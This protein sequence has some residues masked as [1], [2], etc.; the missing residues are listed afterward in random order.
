M[1]RKVMITLLVSM[2][3][4]SSCG[5]ADDIEEVVSSAI[6]TTEPQQEAEE[7]HQQEVEEENT[8]DGVEN[9]VEEEPDKTEEVSD[10]E[11]YE[12]LEEAFNDPDV[13]LGIESSIASMEDETTSISFDVKGNNF[14]MIFKILD[15][16]WIVDNMAERLAEALDEGGDTF[17]NMAAAF[18]EELGFEAGTC[19]VT[20]RYTDPD[21]NVL[22]EKTFVNNFEDAAEQEQ[23]VDEE[24]KAIREEPEQKVDKVEQQAVEKE[25]IVDYNQ[26]GNGAGEQITEDESAYF[27]EAEALW[28]EHGAKMA[29]NWETFREVYAHERGTGLSKDDA[30]NKLYEMFK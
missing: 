13:R 2:I 7:Q 17:K 19:T 26:L 12:T 5:K 23:K 18:D 10:S 28:A 22:A 27:A 11:N 8:V 24:Q 30:F 4:L 6:E 9:V 15:S 21:D 3:C 20:V 25:P 14:I 1:K 29:V 16:S